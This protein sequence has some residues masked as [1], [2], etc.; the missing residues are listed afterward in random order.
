MS[1]RIF[2]FSA[3]PA[4]LPEPVLQEAQRDLWDFAGTGIGILEHSHRGGPFERVIEET[5]ADCR[6]LAGIPASYKVLFL[7]GGA[8]LQFAMLPANFLPDGRAADYIDTG[9]WSQKA[10]HEA[11]Y[12]GSVHVAASAKSANYTYIPSAAETHWSERPAYAHFTSNNTIFGA[13]FRSEPVPPPGVWLACDASSDIY[14][15]PIDVTRYGVIYAGAQKNLGPAGVTLVI[16]R[17]DL[18]EPPVRELPTMLRYRVHAE[19]GSLYNTPCS[20]GIYLM[21]RVFKWLLAQGG[22]PAIARRNEDKAAVLY[23][24]LD[25]EPFYEVP[26]RRDCRS[27]MNVVFRTPSPELDKRF[28]AEATKAGLDGLKGHRSAGGMRASIYN[29]FPR[30]GCEALVQF[31]KDFAAKNG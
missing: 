28:V 25:G 5:E 13:Q 15:K 3:G 11:G 6:A 31:M 22:L 14:S 4:V 12:Y 7:Q 21:G 16:V 19:Q 1:Q 29:A 30:A 8:S 27:L 24:Y 26:V 17:E 9:A 2:N 20:F 10:I 23:D 18:L